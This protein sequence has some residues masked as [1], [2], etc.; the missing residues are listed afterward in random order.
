MIATDPAL[1]VCLHERTAER[2]ERVVMQYV[3]LCA[4][5]ARKFHRTGLDRADLEQIAAIG[6]LKAYDRYDPKNGTPFE[7][8][9]WLFI[10]GELMHFVRDQERIVRAPRRL[11]AIERRIHAAGEHL[12]ARNGCEP[13]RDDLARHLGLDRK[14]V[15]EAW[16]YRDR[17]NVDSIDAMTPR[18]MR[19][20]MYEF[21]GVEDALLVQQALARLTGL[22]CSIIVAMYANG[23]TQNEVA[24]R[25]G[26]SRR[27]ISR[28]HRSALKKMQPVW[29]STID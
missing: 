22:E 8:F 6:L 3:Y 25:L 11:R 4:R 23:Y 19:S 24:S 16:H 12:A 29:V 10:V 14:T 5:G 17:A 26:Y 27:H 15:D 7:A 13:T 18:Q 28:L 2:R 1:D 20:C 9:A 21:E